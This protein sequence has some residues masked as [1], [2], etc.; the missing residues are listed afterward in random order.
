[1]AFLGER[2]KGVP[3]PDERRIARLIAD[4]DDS[5]ARREK[6][7]R[8]L[9]SLG[10]RG[11]PAL[12]RALQGQASVEV[13]R[14]VER[15]LERLGSSTEAPPPELVRLRVVE[16]LEANGT[17]EARKLLAELAAGPAASPLTREAKAS[18]ERLS[19]RPPAGRP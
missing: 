19:R 1:V 16:A 8:E 17:T 12:R 7:Y 15:L 9:V 18:L 13:R 4:L 5:F 10:A 14:R 2:L 6:A 11:A 3:A